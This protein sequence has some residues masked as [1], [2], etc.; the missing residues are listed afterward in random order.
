MPHCAVAKENILQELK[1]TYLLLK[2]LVVLV[3]EEGIVCKIGI[4]IGHDVIVVAE[5]IDCSVRPFAQLFPGRIRNRQRS[6]GRNE[7]RMLYGLEALA[8]CCVVVESRFAEIFQRPW[9]RKHQ[10]K[11]H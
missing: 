4:S 5:L 8:L 10:I 9:E 11:N 7:V 6:I 1:C 2:V 3:T